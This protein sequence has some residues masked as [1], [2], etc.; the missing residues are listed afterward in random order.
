MSGALAQ[1][2]RARLLAA[3]GG[4]AH[5]PMIFKRHHLGVQVAATERCYLPGV[6][7]RLV[8]SIHDVAPASARQTARWCADADALGIP[9]SLLVIPGPWRGERLADHPDYAALLRERRA[10][11]DEIMVHGWNHRAGPEG[12]ALRR[13]VGRVVARGAAEFAALDRTA[14]A[15]KLR[16]ALQVMAECGLGTTGFTPPGWLASPEAERAL[17]AAGF[18]HTTTHFGVKDLRTGHLHRGFALSHRPGGGW[19]ERVGAE[20][21]E[22]AARRT[23][24]RGGLVRLALHPDDLSRPGL[25]ET[26]LR[27]AAAA[28]AAG[29]RASTYA[30]LIGSVID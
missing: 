3:G 10:G 5:G 26:T 2:R 19:S 30:D 29:A 14:A 6:C 16:D 8:V 13:G 4:S 11:G 15:A 18:T 17:V 7:A 25:R 23:A 24:A 28:L 12:S 1:V 20:V 27:A 9:V 21:F 22:R